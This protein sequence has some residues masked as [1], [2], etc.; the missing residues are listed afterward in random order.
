[1]QIIINCLAIKQFL[2]VRKSYTKFNK[3]IEKIQKNKS[4]LALFKVEMLWIN[5][6]KIISITNLA[7]NRI[8]LIKWK[9][10]DKFFQKY[11]LNFNIILIGIKSIMFPTS[12][13]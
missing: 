4:K 2:L 5:I 11:I 7:N 12:K 9:K 8:D 1:M 13:S 6:K 3:Y 10:E